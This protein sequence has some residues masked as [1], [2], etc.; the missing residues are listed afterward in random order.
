MSHKKCFSYYKLLSE[1]M[2][3]LDKHGVKFLMAVFCRLQ[4]RIPVI[5]EPSANTSFPPPHRFHLSQITSSNDYSYKS[6]ANREVSN[7][8]PF[9]R[10]MIQTEY[11]DSEKRYDSDR[12]TVPTDKD[13]ILT[14]LNTDRYCNNP[15]CRLTV[16]LADSLYG[17]CPP[18]F[19]V[20]ACLLCLCLPPQP[21]T[22]F[23]CSITSNPYFGGC[24]YSVIT[25]AFFGLNGD[26]VGL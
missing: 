12:E 13:T 16:F 1:V 22:N 11:I 4:S 24:C 19:S 14:R 5:S 10:D 20:F 21:T 6:T 18:A 23:F 7:C 2:R 25:G 3:F 9:R 15:K 8:S 17:D 26:F